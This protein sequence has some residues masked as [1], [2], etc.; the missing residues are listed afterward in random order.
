MYV[1]CRIG[2]EALLQEVGDGGAAAAA[3][4]GIGMHFRRNQKEFRSLVFPCRLVWVG[5]PL[6]EWE[7]G[8][9]VTGWLGAQGLVRG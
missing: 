3:R 9:V 6:V 7:D 8:W 4:C 1:G 2:R 5:A